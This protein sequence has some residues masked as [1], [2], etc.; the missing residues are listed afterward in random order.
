MDPYD[1]PVFEEEEVVKTLPRS[2]SV[3]EHSDL[4]LGYY[5]DKDDYNRRPKS[6]EPLNRTPPTKPPRLR[7]SSGVERPKFHFHDNSNKAKGGR[8]SSDEIKVRHRKRSSSSDSRRHRSPVPQDLDE[9]N[10]ERKSPFLEKL[11]EI[12]HDASDSSFNKQTY[13]SSVEFRVLT[14]TPDNSHSISQ[15]GKNEFMT[16]DNSVVY[17]PEIVRSSKSSKY[18]DV[19]Q[20]EVKENQDEAIYIVQ[21]YQSNENKAKESKGK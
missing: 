2:L 10:N 21:E 14:N 3:D 9:P 6:A 1:H 18:M 17:Q 5:I 11:D 7:R 13:S 19:Q 20:K 12:E 4:L 8:R 16:I 15:G